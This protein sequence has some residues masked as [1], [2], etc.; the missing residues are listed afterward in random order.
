MNSLI[1]EKSL[2][3]ISYKRFEKFAKKLKYY[4]MS[5]TKKQAENICKRLNEELVRFLFLARG[6]HNDNYL[7]ETKERKYVLRIENN[8]QFKNLKKE[9]GLLKSLKPNLAPKPYFFDNSHKIIPKDY[10]VEEFMAGRTPKKLNNKFLILMAKWLKNLHSQKVKSHR[11][12]LLNAIKPYYRNFAKYKSAINEELANYL[13]NLL[14]ITLNFLKENNK[15]FGNY[16]KFSLLHRDLSKENILLNKN[17]IRV[18]DWEFAGYGLPEYDLVYFIDSYKLNEKKR[19]LFLRA[20]KYPNSEMARKRLTA[21]YALMVCGGIGYSVWRLDLIN[22]GKINKKEKNKIMVRLKKDA[23]IF[24]KTLTKLQ[25]SHMIR[26]RKLKLSDIPHIAKISRGEKA[27]EDYP[28][29][30]SAEVFRGILKD[31]STT[32]LVAEQNKK[33]IGFMEFSNDKAAKRLFIWAVAVSKKHRGKGVG[34]LLIKK[35]EEIAKKT[36][37]VRTGFAV[38]EWNKP[39]QRLAKKLRY[40]SLGRHIWYDKKI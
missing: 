26:I 27:V 7:I 6:N 34:S 4:K 13:D 22:K 36:K 12:F 5:I 28:G 21:I 17:E 33:P 10:F 2:N 29:E 38:K 9:Y 20:Y 35:A 3:C 23:K 1:Y 19:N 37:S 16:K 15:I 30:Y 31:K 39:M 11:Y 25:F 8:S 24:E 14:N 32:V 18:L 40:L